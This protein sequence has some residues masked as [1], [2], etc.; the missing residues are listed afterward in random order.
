LQKK[1]TLEQVE[2]ANEK[3]FWK[4]FT[5][6]ENAVVLLKD[7]LETKANVSTFIRTCNVNLGKHQIY[8]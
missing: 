2:E 4:N 6:D 8:V 3:L 5:G 7:F 1:G